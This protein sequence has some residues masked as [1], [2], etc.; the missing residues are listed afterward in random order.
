ML[1]SAVECSAVQRSAVQCSAVQC[2]VINCSVVQCS[3][4]PCRVLHCSA[5]L[6]SAVQCSAV[7]FSA[8]QRS[9]VQCRVWFDFP[10]PR[11]DKFTLIFSISKFIS[12]YTTCFGDAALIMCG[13]QLEAG[14]KLSEVTTHIQ[15]VTNLVPLSPDTDFLPQVCLP[16][17]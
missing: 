16:P 9:A 1:Y 8:V 17:C 5:L 10:R 11:L 6:C 15:L 7:Q 12:F 14:C 3:A 4:A 13:L 2:S